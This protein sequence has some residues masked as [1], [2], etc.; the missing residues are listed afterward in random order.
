MKFLYNGIALP[1]LPEWDKAAYPYAVMQYVPDSVNQYHHFVYCCEQRPEWKSSYGA[2]AVRVKGGYLSTKYTEE[3]TDNWTDFE[4]YTNPSAISEDR[5]WWTNFDVLNAED[6][7]VYFAASYPI[8]AE[9]GEEITIYEPNHVPV[10]QLNPAALM[11]G[12]MV[13]QAIRRARG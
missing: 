2:W 4:A 1:P 7:S 6:G 3:D 10:P 8:D 9:T 13:G 11:Q 5:V 12:Y